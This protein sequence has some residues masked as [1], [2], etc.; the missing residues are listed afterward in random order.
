M[1]CVCVCVCVCGVFT[2]HHRFT[3]VRELVESNN[4]NNNDNDASS[5]QISF[6]TTP[7]HSAAAPA[8]CLCR[9]NKMPVMTMSVAATQDVQLCSWKGSLAVSVPQHGVVNGHCSWPCCVSTELAVL[10]QYRCMEWWTVRLPFERQ[11]CC[12]I[13]E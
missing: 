3:I 11:S 10:C 5:V 12:L 9:D 8:S 6:N 4:D 1:V 2:F 13:G 7:S